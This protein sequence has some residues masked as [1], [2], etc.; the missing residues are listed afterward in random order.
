MGM[1]RGD[2]DPSRAKLYTLFSA[3]AHILIAYSTVGLTMELYLHRNDL[4]SKLETIAV[5]ISH[6]ILCLKLYVLDF[7]TGEV[8]TIVNAIKGNFFIHGDELSTE[9]RLVIK[10]VL[11]HAKIITMSYFAVGATASVMYHLMSPIVTRMHDEAEQREHNATHET[12]V[13]LPQKIW[14]PF[15]ESQSPIYEIVY[16]YTALIGLQET[17]SLM[18]IQMFSMALMIYLSGQFELLGEELRST[19]SN[20]ALRLQAGGRAPLQSAGQTGYFLF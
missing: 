14:F 6:V 12:E 16:V 13:I 15:D 11:R 7:R 1:W 10:K 19:S 4:L 5:S 18:M 17:F 8:Q 2:M 9:N 20:V 3:A